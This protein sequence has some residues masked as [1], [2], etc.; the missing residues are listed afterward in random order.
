MTKLDK[1]IIIFA[2]ICLLIFGAK[3]FTMVFVT[4]DFSDITIV[5]AG[6]IFSIFFIMI[7]ADNKRW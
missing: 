2:L 7:L 6:A 3:A 1:L 4:K 5:L